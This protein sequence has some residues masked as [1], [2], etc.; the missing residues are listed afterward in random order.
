MPRNQTAAAALF[1]TALD[2]ETQ[3]AQQEQYILDGGVEGD[4]EEGMMEEDMM[5]EEDMD[6]MGGGEWLYNVYMFCVL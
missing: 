3:A 4:L 5:Y 2:L 6:A 1:Q